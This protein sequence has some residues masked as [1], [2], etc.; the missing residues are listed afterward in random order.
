MP[1]RRAPTPYKPA[2]LARWGTELHDRF[3]L[4]HFIWDD[5]EDVVT[6]LNEA[7]YP[8]ELAWFAAHRD[9]R[10]PLLGERA[11]LKRFFVAA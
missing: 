3:M 6:E 8:F 1:D 2:R 7:G 5:L 4:P 9:F 11:T 10:F